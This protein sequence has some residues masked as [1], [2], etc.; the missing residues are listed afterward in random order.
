MSD[1]DTQLSISGRWQDA[2]GDGMPVIVAEDA[3]LALTLKACSFAKFCNAGAD[4]HRPDPISRAFK[5]LRWSLGP[6]WRSMHKA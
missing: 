1:P 4:L 6:N 2:A 5:L 3:N